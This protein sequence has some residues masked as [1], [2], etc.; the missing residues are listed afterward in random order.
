MS[1][2]TDQFEQ[3]LTNRIRSFSGLALPSS[4]PLWMNGLGITNA[5]QIT[6]VER[7]GA[8][9]YKTDIVIFF[10]NGA[11]LKVS[12]KMSSAD[13]FGNW[14]SHTRVLEEFGADIFQKLTVDCTQWANSWINNVNA[15]LFVGVSICFGK[16]TGN[17]SRDFTD[18]FTTNDIVKIVAGTGQGI[19]TA[20]CLYSS[21]DL[22]QTIDQLF[23][24]LKPIDSATIQQLSQNFKIAYRPINPLTEGTNRGKCTYTQFSPHQPL[25]ALTTVDNLMDLKQLGRFEQVVPNS[26]NHNRILNDLRDCYNIF[27]PRKL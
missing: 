25:Q 6:N 9:G 12:A 2:Y 22:P 19:E 11:L 5:N 10:D 21:S 16:R 27:I 26:L 7:I 13:Y 18:V 8:A 17:T 3:Q 4:I 24:V 15:S 1:A 23:Q 14:Y 20:N